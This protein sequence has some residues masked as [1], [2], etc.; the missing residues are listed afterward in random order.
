MHT[1]WITAL[2]LGDLTPPLASRGT[3]HMQCTYTREIK[4]DLIKGEKI[5]PRLAM[6][7]LA[8]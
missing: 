1:L 4:R 3:T 5:Y 6:A 8:L 2:V 7:F